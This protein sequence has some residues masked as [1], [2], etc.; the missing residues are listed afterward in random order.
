MCVLELV[1]VLTPQNAREL[2]DDPNSVWRVREKKKEKK[3]RKEKTGGWKR[4]GTTAREV[5]VASA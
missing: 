2:D 5:N 4:T 1:K 3:T